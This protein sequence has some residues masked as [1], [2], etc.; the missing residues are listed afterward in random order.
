[1]PAKVVRTLTVSGITGATYKVMESPIAGG[2]TAAPIDCTT[3]ADANKAKVADPQPELKPLVVKCALEDNPMPTIGSTSTLA[4]SGT[5][6]DGS[7]YSYS[8]TG[9][10]SDT[11]ASSV[12]VGGERVPTVD[13][14]FTPAGGGTTATTTSTSTTTT[15]A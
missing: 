15:G 9:F 7:V 3:F 2:A 11:T 12:T 5:F 14:E 4:V 8:V 1:M 6:T 10:I 13:V